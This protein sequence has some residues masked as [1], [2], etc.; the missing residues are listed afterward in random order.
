MVRMEKGRVVRWCPQGPNRT[1][2]S[3]PNS[4]GPYCLDVAHGHGFEA[5]LQSAC[6]QARSYG[7]TNPRDL[8]DFQQHLQKKGLVRKG[9]R[10][11][12]WCPVGQIS[13]LTR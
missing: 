1:P 7:Q 9:G 3:L 2:D 12:V 4:Q 6:V 11:G 13:Q 10:V 8:F 5:S